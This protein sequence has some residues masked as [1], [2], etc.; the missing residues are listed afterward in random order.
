MRLSKQEKA[1]K[2]LALSKDFLQIQGS[3]MYLDDGM[4]WESKKKSYQYSLEKRDYHVA[5][6]GKSLRKIFIN[7]Y[8]PLSMCWV[9][10]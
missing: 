4:R 5:T 10:Y 2:S 1:A 8:W 7:I 6:Q 3:E 9:L